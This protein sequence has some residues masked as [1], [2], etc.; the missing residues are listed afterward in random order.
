MSPAIPVQA[1]VISVVIHSLW[2]G[3]PVAVKFGLLVFP[4]MW[5]AFLRFVLAIACIALWAWYRGIRIWPRRSEFF[6][7]PCQATE[8]VADDRPAGQPTRGR[9]P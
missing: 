6:R 9:S 8:R 5:T 7:P 1:I 3:N 4:P 2:G